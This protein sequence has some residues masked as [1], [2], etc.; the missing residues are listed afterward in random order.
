MALQEL[1]AP[2][3]ALSAEELDAWRQIPPAVA[4]DCMNRTQV[5]AAAIKPISQGLSLCGQ[6][7]T[8]T[9]MVGDCAPICRLVSRARPGEIIMVDAGGVEDTAVWGGVMAE[10]AVYR[11]LGGAVVDGAIRDV[12]DMRK[13]GLTMFCRSIV[14][15]GPHEGFGGIIDGLISVGGVPVRSG[16]IVLGNDDGVVVVPLEQSSAI[17]AA[18]QAH[19]LKEEAWLRDIRNGVS[20]LGKVQVHAGH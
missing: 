7:R 19:L 18:A 14:P 4:S 20:V 2:F 11:Q 15:R 5:M 17:L 1:D 8:V 13:V 3:R 9:V 6:A 16:D 12:A 10:E